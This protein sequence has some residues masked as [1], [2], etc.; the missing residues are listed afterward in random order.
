VVVWGNAKESAL[1]LNQLRD[2]GMKQEVFFSDRIVSPEFLKIAGKNANG[3]VSTC[4]YN[5]NSDNPK[6]KQFKSNYLKKF[7]QEADVFAIH[8]YDGMN[9][10]LAA[11]QKVGLN[12]VLIRDVLLD[13]K[14]FQGYEGISGKK[15]FDGT[16]N[17][18]SPI[19]M[20]EVK[21]GKFLFTP[22]PPMDLKD[23]A[24][25]STGQY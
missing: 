19:F 10:I 23:R 12:R 6:L 21:D 16:W 5:P 22:A 24:S 2:M 13:L 3:V 4:Q 9:M 14:T 18:I 17:N 25:M 20:S 8:A 11:I 1:I 7:G 15:E